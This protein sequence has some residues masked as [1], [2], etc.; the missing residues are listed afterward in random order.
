[1]A[2]DFAAGTD[3][4]KTGLKPNQEF[5][6]PRGHFQAI[7]EAAGKLTGDA[8]DKALEDLAEVD[9]SASVVNVVSGPFRTVCL[10]VEAANP[11]EA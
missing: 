9:Q 11:V 6:V 7:L 4:A 3:P 8:I 5:S 10:A 1:M 2:R